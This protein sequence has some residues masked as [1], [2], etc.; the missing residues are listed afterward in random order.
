VLV[1][2]AAVVTAVVQPTGSAP[3]PPDGAPVPGPRLF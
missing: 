1:E 2:G 3:R